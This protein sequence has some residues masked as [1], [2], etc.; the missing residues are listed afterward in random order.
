MKKENNGWKKE[1]WI[2]FLRHLQKQI[3]ILILYRKNLKINSIG[4]PRN[5]ETSVLK[6]FKLI[7]GKNVGLIVGLSKFSLT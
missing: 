7:N 4:F 2:F 6:L 5:S 1:M 3:Q